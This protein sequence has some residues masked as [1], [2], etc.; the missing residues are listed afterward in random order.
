MNTKHLHHPNIGWGYM[1]A[2][3]EVLAAFH[4]AQEHYKP[5]HLL[6]IG[7]HL[8]HST[9]YQLEIYKDLE[10][11]VS[12]SPYMDR[13]GKPHDR[14]PPEWRW[15]TAIDLHKRYKGK[16]R[17]IP[18]KAHM[19]EEEIR[20]NKFDFALI[21]GGHSYEPAKFDMDL[22]ISM[23]IKAFLIDNFELKPVRDAF[24]DT[25]QLREVKRFKYEQTFKGKTKVNQLTLVEVINA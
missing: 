8:G 16:W 24:T 9:T 13:N 22:C 17:W 6:E 25:P 7:F 11:M 21:D 14:I 2:T 4:Y 3:D 15:Q 1:P 23:G 18:G 10:D 20:I 19:V 12:V 5:K